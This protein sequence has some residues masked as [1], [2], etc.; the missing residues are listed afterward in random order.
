MIISSINTI[1]NVRSY[2][3][4]DKNN[5][6]SYTNEQK[7]ENKD[8]LKIYPQPYIQTFGAAKLS[9]EESRIN[10]LVKDHGVSIE[11]AKKFDSKTPMDLKYHLYTEMPEYMYGKIFEYIINDEEMTVDRLKRITEIDKKTKLQPI[12][13]MALEKLEYN[14][15]KGIQR[16]ADELNISLEEAKV[17]NDFYM[18]IASIHSTGDE[19]EIGLN[20][21]KGYRREKF[22]L[23]VNFVM[24][25][26]AQERGINFKNN[27]ALR[28]HWP[29]RIDGNDS[30]FNT[31]NETPWQA[32]AWAIPNMPV[33]DWHINS[34]KLGEYFYHNEKKNWPLSAQFTV[35]YGPE[36]TGKTY[37]VNKAC[38]HLEHFGVKIESIKFSPDNHEENCKKIRETYI[39]AY[40]RFKET[41]KY[42]VIKFEDNIEDYFNRDNNQNSS[43]ELK[44]INGINYEIEDRPDYLE[45]IG[46]FCIGAAR[47]ISNVGTPG[48]HSIP[49][50][51]MKDFNVEEMLKFSL[52]KYGEKESAEELDY[53]KVAEIMKEDLIALTP[54][55]IELMVKRAKRHK[56]TPE[57]KITAD[58]ILNEMHEYEQSDSS[59]LTINVRK[60]FRKDR[61]SLKAYNSRSPYYNKEIKRNTV[62]EDVD[63]IIDEIAYGGE[64]WYE[65]QLLDLIAIAGY[66]HSDIPL[67][68]GSYSFFQ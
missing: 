26:V 57:Q 44:A 37:M 12:F 7:Q 38:E 39:N 67:Q 4:L 23:A 14:L 25:I 6:I 18:P 52:M 20:A 59:T 48:M 11:A 56:K 24:P 45:E 51:V 41:G 66:K 61:L 40:Q 33:P 15:T 47:S 63:K 53:K 55:E 2:K 31:D 54:K 29:Y 58:S 21:I 42:T 5:K 10:Y 65:D 43:P 30:Y 68:Y 13:A 17:Y 27:D 19:N 22:D 46:V 16:L 9:K 50:G 32:L 36:G 8:F 28:Y 3:T 49:I 60:A 34:S 35:L 62:K 64:S 1:Q